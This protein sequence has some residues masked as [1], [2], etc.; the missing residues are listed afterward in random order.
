MT[1]FTDG[2]KETCFTP[3]PAYI[4]P[5]LIQKLCDA[6][7][8]AIEDNS[9]PSLILAATFMLDFV[10]IHPFRDG[11]GRMSRIIMLLELHQLGF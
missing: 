6:Y 3:P 4:T 2:H 11:N 7:N 9:F 1:T 10:S 8:N 5:E